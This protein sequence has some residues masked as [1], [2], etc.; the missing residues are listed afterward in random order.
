MNPTPASL[1]ERL[2]Q[3]RESGAWERFVQLYTPLL[4][5]WARRL[6]LQ[7]SDAADLVQDVFV[8]LVQKLPQFHYD[9]DKSFRG[10]LRTVLQNKWNDRA[11]KKEASAWSS[12]GETLQQATVQP[13]IDSL[14]ET[15]YRQQL[16]Q[17]ALHLMQSEFAPNTW[18]ACWGHVVEGRSAAAVAAELGIA[19]GS[20]YVARSRVLSRLRQELHGLLD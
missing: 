3:P 16:V 10:W 17:R 6:G 14:S 13:E 8:L 5:F 9:R 15:E 19:P 7:E 1:L 18:R 20:V 12:H 2:K 4:Y 11:R